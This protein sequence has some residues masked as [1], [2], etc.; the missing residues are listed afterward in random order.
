MFHKIPSKGSYGTWRRCR[1]G[2]SRPNDVIR[3][4]RGLSL[5]PRGLS[6]LNDGFRSPRGL[7]VIVFEDYREQ[8]MVFA[9]HVVYDVVAK[10]NPN[11]MILFVVRSLHHCTRGLPWPDDS[12]HRPRGLRRVFWGLP[13]PKV[14]YSLL[15]HVDWVIVFEEYRDWTMVFVVYVD[16][17]V[18]SEVYHDQTMVFVVYVDYDVVAKVNHDQTIL[19]VVQV[20]YVIVAELYHN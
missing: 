10:V 13:L 19:F 2:Q 12:F 16:Y 7:N 9:I 11:Q 15:V 20:D 17:T 1:Q 14:Y 6:W 18:I 5:C 8:T 4:P 3:R